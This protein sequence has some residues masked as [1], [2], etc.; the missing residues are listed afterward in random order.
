VGNSTPVDIMREEFLRK[1]F[2]EFLI[3]QYRCGVFTVPEVA[4]LCKRDK[5]CS[6]SDVN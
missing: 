6:E 5:R 1:E 3:R 2:A 4:V